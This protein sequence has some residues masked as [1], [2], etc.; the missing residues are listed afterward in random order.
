MQVLPASEASWENARPAA[1]GASRASLPGLSAAADFEEWVR[2]IDRLVPAE[3][4][5]LFVSPHRLIARFFA[6]AWH[7]VSGRALQDTDHDPAAR[8]PELV[9]AVLGLVRT[10]AR[11]YFR[12][13][14]E[15]VENVPATGPVLLVGNHNGGLLPTDGFFTALAI[16]DHHGPERAVHALAHDFLFDDPT[17]ERYAARVGM[18]RA[19]EESALRAFA[20]CGCVLVY[21]GSDYD[22]F[23][24]FRERDRV[25]LGGR[26]GF[27]RL[28]L[29]A[30]VPIVPVI[31]AGTHE[32]F[33]V[34]SRGDRLARFVHAHAL[35]RT[36]VLPL[37]VAVPWGVVPGF[38]PYIPLPAQT[39]LA[40]GEPL[41][42]P[43]LG[44][45]DAEDPDLLE[46]LYRDVE[47]EMQQILDRL[48]RGRRFLVGRPEDRSGHQRD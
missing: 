20:A 32:Q 24:P 9:S 17:L 33:I 23:R 10:L 18:L 37:V 36:E 15:D 12:L 28:A 13:R 44:P 25:V 11:T 2:R 30:G 34:L 3:D 46:H 5:R 29:R 45:K 38:V 4:R 7:R 19:S 27:L 42:F 6:F 16:H 43:G 8:D 39:T 41:R 35:A 22:A 26:K 1:A 31:S 14:I 48:S 47:R 40:F 21:P